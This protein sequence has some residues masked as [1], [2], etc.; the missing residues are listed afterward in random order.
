MLQV[1]RT[2]A[3]MPFKMYLQLNAQ[4]KVVQS[5]IQPHLHITDTSLTEADFK[6]IKKYYALAVPAIL[7]EAFCS[8]QERSMKADHTHVLTY[9]G[10]ITGL[11]DDFYDKLFLSQAEIQGLIA[12]PTEN[13]NP[14]AHVRLF[15]ALYSSALAQIKNKELFFAYCQAVNQ[16]QIN[17]L[18]QKGPLSFDQLKDITDEKGGYS[19]LF[20]RSAIDLPFTENEKALLYQVGALMQLANDIFDVYKDLQDGIHT[21][22]TDATS[23]ANLRQLF[24]AEYLKCVELAKKINVS[25]SNLLRFFCRINMAVFARALVCLDFY[26]KQGQF[27]PFEMQRQQLVCDM[28]TFAAILAS[29]RHTCKLLKLVK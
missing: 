1:F 3:C 4:K 24:M 15:V 19:L 27:K 25:R 29:F 26:E 7:G 11:F 14:L 21:L 2:F 6:K 12:K 18:A 17:S 23:I 5:L 9:L 28:D 16:A 10:A 8:L 13:T 22:V 20:Y